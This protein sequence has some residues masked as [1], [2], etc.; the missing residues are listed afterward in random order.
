[1]DKIRKS[2]CDGKTI[3]VTSG[4]VKE[5]NG[6]GF[7]DI[8]DIDVDGSVLIDR[9]AVD[10]LMCAYRSYH[11]LHSE[12]LIP[13]MTIRT[14]D[15]WPV[16]VGQGGEN[17]YPLL[18]ESYYSKGRLIVLN[19]P[20]RFSDIYKFPKEALFAIKQRIMENMS[21]IVRSE[22]GVSLF[23]YDNDHFIIES[24]LPHNSKISVIL[25]GLQ[26]SLTNVETGQV[27]N[28]RSEENNSI[29]ALDLSPSNFMVFRINR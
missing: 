2:L 3:V 27:I 8:I 11:E 5:L 24:F 14:N 7:K 12:M 6:C 17:G 28:G 10:M 9:I 23:C 19:V 15:V 4:L 29:F 26:S 13:K 1:L 16:I 20:E 21:I 18:V 22:A 25:K